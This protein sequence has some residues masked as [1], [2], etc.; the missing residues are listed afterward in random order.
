VL[1]EKTAILSLAGRV[2]QSALRKKNNNHQADS[3]AFPAGPRGQPF[4]G[5]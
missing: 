2:A 4:D 1:R 5:W 3:S